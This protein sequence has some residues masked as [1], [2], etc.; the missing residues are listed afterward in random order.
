MYPSQYASW[1]ASEDESSSHEGHSCSPNLD[2][3]VPLASDDQYQYYSPN[4]PDSG[5]SVSDPSEACGSRTTI[6]CSEVDVP[7][8][9]KLNTPNSLFR[10][11]K[12]QHLEVSI[13][14]QQRWRLRCPDCNKWSQMSIPSTVPLWSEGQFKSLSNHRGSKK[15]SQAVM[16]KQKQLSAGNVF[17]GPI[18]RP[19]SITSDQRFH[20]N[21]KSTQTVQGITDVQAIQNLEPL[22]TN[23]QADKHHKD[24]R[25][26]KQ[27]RLYT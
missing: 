22:S 21:N 11:F 4:S 16:K 26:Y 5:F 14:L 10:L 8:L 6:V 19:D 7:E 20:T 12:A 1:F 9:L 23:K 3:Q 25:V 17:D 15:Y 13:S 2:F 27:Y 18:T 24:Y